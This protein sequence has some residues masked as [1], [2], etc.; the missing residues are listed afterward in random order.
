MTNLRQHARLKPCQIRLPHICSGNAEETVLAHVRLAGVTGVGM[1][2][3]DLLGAWAC[4][5]CHE[6]TERCKDDDEIMRAYYE[7]V[8][9]TQNMLIEAGLVKW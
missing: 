7:G 8:I 3:P 5:R 9:R 4:S 6:V 2:A 1:K